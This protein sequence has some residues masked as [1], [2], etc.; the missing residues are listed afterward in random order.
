M[1][2]IC[3]DRVIYTSAT[4]SMRAKFLANRNTIFPVPG[5]HL[6]HLSEWSSPD[7]LT[8]NVIFDAVGHGDSLGHMALLPISA[9]PYRSIQR[10]PPKS[11]FI[12]V[13]TKDKRKK[14][15]GLKSPYPLIDINNRPGGSY[16]RPAGLARYERKVN[17]SSQSDSAHLP[18]SPKPGGGCAL[19]DQLLDALGEIVQSMDEFG[20]STTGQAIKNILLPI[21]TFVTSVTY[22]PDI[23]SP[24]YWFNFVLQL[25]TMISHIPF[26]SDTLHMFHCLILDFK[27]L[28]TS[29]RTVEGPLDYVVT[30]SDDYCKPCDVSEHSYDIKSE[31]DSFT[32]SS[33][34]SAVKNPLHMLKNHAIQRSFIRMMIFMGG[35]LIAGGSRITGLLANTPG[36][37]LLTQSVNKLSRAAADEVSGAPLVFASSI[38][39]YLVTGGVNLAQGL[40]GT[41]NISQFSEDVQHLATTGVAIT[42]GHSVE[43]F[44][45]ERLDYQVDTG[46][47]SS[48]W[49]SEFDR[50][51]ALQT[52]L[53][54]ASF[55]MSNGD[56]SAYTRAATNLAATG[57]L[58]DSIHYNLP[59][60]QGM[61]F[62]IN[63]K[64]SIGKST[65]T[66][67]L[68]KTIGMAH[69]G[70]VLRKDQIATA[71]Q[72]DK[73]NASITARTKI[74]IIDDALASKSDKDDPTDITNNPARFILD[75]INPGGVNLH[76]ASVEEKGKKLVDLSAV[77]CSTNCENMYIDM[78]TMSTPEAAARRTLLITVELKE[79]FKN[80]EGGLDIMKCADYYKIGPGKGL[81]SSL[82][83]P[84]WDFTVLR[85]DLAA[86]CAED[87]DQVRNLVM[88]G[89]KKPCF[90]P[91]LYKPCIVYLDECKLPSDIS[92]DVKILQD[93][94]GRSYYR[95]EKLSLFGLTTTV[96]WLYR[97]NVTKRD[98]IKD[99]NTGDK[100]INSCS[101]TH[102][103]TGACFCTARVGETQVQFTERIAPAVPMFDC[104]VETNQVLFEY[105][106]GIQSES[107]T[108]IHVPLNLLSRTIDSWIVKDGLWCLINFVFYSITSI[109]AVC[110]STWIGS[111]LFSFVARMSFYKYFVD[112]YKNYHVVADH[113]RSKFKVDL[114]SWRIS[115][116]YRRTKS[117][118]TIFA[119][120]M[121]YTII[122][123]LMVNGNSNLQKIA[124]PLFT[125]LASGGDRPAETV[126]AVRTALNESPDWRLIY[127]GRATELY[128]RCCDFRLP[129]CMISERSDSIW[130]DKISYK[131]V[132][133]TIGG[134]IFTTGAIVA[135]LRMFRT[136][137]KYM[138]LSQSG[139]VPIV[140][141]P[142]P[143]EPMKASAYTGTETARSLRTFNLDTFAK[144]VYQVKEASNV[145]SFK[146]MQKHH[147]ATFAEKNTHYCEVKAVYKIGSTPTVNAS[148][149]CISVP[150]A[151]NKTLNKN[152]HVFPSHVFPL[153]T[154]GISH[155]DI[156]HVHRGSQVVDRVRISDL[157]RWS[158]SYENLDLVVIPLKGS[159]CKDMIDF[160]PESIVPHV[161]NAYGFYS[162]F[163]VDKSDPPTDDFPHHKS[164]NITKSTKDKSLV[165]YHD[166]NLQT[167]PVDA[168]TYRARMSYSYIGTL[169]DGHTSLGDCCLPVF[170]GGG[171]DNSI[172]GFHVGG[173]DH[174]IS[175][176][177]VSR[178]MLIEACEHY[179]PALA[180]ESDEIVF[181][182]V[183][184]DTGVLGVD[185]HDS[186]VHPM[187]ALNS[188]PDGNFDYIGNVDAIPKYSTA[189]TLSPPD[190]RSGISQHMFRDG[191]FD[192]AIV[193][194][195]RVIKASSEENTWAAYQKFTL[196]ACKHKITGDAD[197]LDYC[198][199]DLE[200][201]LILE[202][203]ASS[204]H[205]ETYP[206][207]QPLTL[208]ESINGQRDVVAANSINLSTATGCLPGAKNRYMTRGALPGPESGVDFHQHPITSC[209]PVLVDDINKIIG[210]INSGESPGCAFT[211]VVKDEPRN[212][213]KAL[214]VIN[215]GSTSYNCV[216]RMYF[217]PILSL[218]A[219]NPLNNEVCVGMNAQSSDWFRI[220]E[221]LTEFPHA[222]NGD[223]QGFDTSLSPAVTRGAVECFISLGRLCGYS[224]QQQ[225][226]MRL[227]ALDIVYPCYI[228]GGAAIRVNGTNPSGNPLTTWLNC[229]CNSI[230]A[231][232]CYYSSL[233]ESKYAT[234]PCDPFTPMDSFGRPLR[235]GVFVPRDVVRFQ[236][237]ESY[238]HNVFAV[239][240]GDD[241]IISVESGSP[242]NQTTFALHAR[243][244]GCVYTTSDKT[245][246]LGIYV[247][248]DRI[249]M[250]NRGFRTYTDP[251]CEIKL[252]LAPLDMESIF[253][254]FYYG[255]WRNGIYPQT[256]E[257]IESAMRELFEWGPN[258][259]NT[260]LQEFKEFSRSIVYTIACQGD[261]PSISAVLYDE[262]PWSRIEPWGDI[263]LSRLRERDP[264]ATLEDVE[265]LLESST[266]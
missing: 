26:P 7:Q 257:N 60:N 25:R 205:M 108:V 99:I 11:N 229:L 249:D 126:T 206:Q 227:L 263:A 71:I 153:A 127:L 69:L 259:Y 145:R 190:I 72:G 193:M 54:T 40:F 152:F 147:C 230:I 67:H 182:M 73:H 59:T 85:Y 213:A 201:R 122:E 116:A 191:S 111:N 196:R 165:T 52:D 117:E 215:V 221:H 20:K 148:Q 83:G 142:P 128:A 228:I 245:S 183:P 121:A 220:H 189:Y 41:N 6:V 138:L 29:D 35:A 181:N 184:S 74:V 250:L 264:R 45:T 197:L 110:V 177:P 233:Y 232:Y 46:K 104:K 22:A 43:A 174:H 159:P 192:P 167:S 81:N 223:F 3:S 118:F 258:V 39:D 246:D 77:I 47:N 236:E 185:V 98:L 21:V 66:E 9:F 88:S 240:Y 150:F 164:F 82:A 137:V 222:F 144:K 106:M 160:F 16:S 53:S 50:L 139:R 194:V 115:R 1:S 28:I 256:A 14:K 38:L 100:D 265:G 262:V 212:P 62:V 4:P 252:V 243:E 176:A 23:Q 131:S 154:T 173:S 97:R 86:H 172:I 48:I 15:W 68:V 44:K 224:V 202:L 58:S 135:V 76:A 112:F 8:P 125:I 156:F 134:A 102:C 49:M 251:N 175:V 87:G 170:A 114:S 158:G 219:T 105:F 18:P 211:C 70:V 89:T 210:L 10:A 171:K 113:G 266:N 235:Q 96:N 253:R 33:F 103:H 163:V 149:M 130:N 61:A 168:G 84:F 178:T 238:D 188:I 80:P 65:L 239:F 261:L 242:L 42:K 92:C 93:R 120:T 37:N 254:P 247:P 200:S 248:W 57:A 51:R 90:R 187:H 101:M 207:L 12:R 91:E 124:L 75:V 13:M 255:T 55:S 63:G 34:A 198:A 237:S 231:R 218:L 146:A 203:K 234:V 109:I 157:F 140:D 226:A 107:H 244:L 195:N 79:A 179:S 94:S 119:F 214:R 27:D 169:T 17:I 132:V 166:L 64:P 162:N 141:T 123:G 30:L 78:S 155:F 204:E 216:V 180:S 225:D 24:H 19:E 161:D 208:F 143:E 260:L 151:C 209:D 56:H 199:R 2:T 95:T 36:R 129:D 5:K 241:N 133:V 217:L 31:G 32:L 136:S 186:V